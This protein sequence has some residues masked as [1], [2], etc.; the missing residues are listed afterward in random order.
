MRI[1]FLPSALVFFSVIYVIT[2]LF[3]VL[4]HGNSVKVVRKRQTEMQHDAKSIK[5]G[6]FFYPEN[7][8][9]LPWKWVIIYKVETKGLEIFNNDE[10]SNQ[11]VF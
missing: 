3:I 4:C 5:G 7:S 11:F 8:K 2:Q 1:N 6:G 10:L 9:Y